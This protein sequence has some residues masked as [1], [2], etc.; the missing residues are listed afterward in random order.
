MPPPRFVVLWTLLQPLLLDHKAMSQAV[1]TGELVH[2]KFD[3]NQKSPVPLFLKFF[4]VCVCVSFTQLALVIHRP[5][6]TVSLCWVVYC[7]CKVYS[8]LQRVL[9]FRNELDWWTRF[10]V[11]MDA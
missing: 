1:G 7:F 10:G 5:Q 9:C 4:K 11:S 6:V 2:M 3:P 8:T